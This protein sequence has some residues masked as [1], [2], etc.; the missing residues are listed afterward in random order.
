MNLLKLGSLRPTMSSVLLTAPFTEAGRRALC[1]PQ[2]GDAFFTHQCF[3]AQ[4]LLICL[5]TCLT[6]VSPFIDLPCSLERHRIAYDGLSNEYLKYS[7]LPSCWVHFTHILVF[8]QHSKSSMPLW[9]FCLFYSFLRSWVKI[10]S[11]DCGCDIS[12]CNSVNFCSV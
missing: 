4:L 7:P 3:L 12:S 1:L 10:F 5:P 8:Y 9:K 2:L 6:T 11:F